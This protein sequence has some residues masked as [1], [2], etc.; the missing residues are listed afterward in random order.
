MLGVVLCTGG[1]PVSVYAADLV[2]EEIV[3]T[4]QKRE[5][6]LQDVPLSITAVT[7]D[8]LTERGIT[9]LSLLDSAVPGLNI[10]QSGSD[11]RPS[12]RGVPT[13]EIDLFN[14][15]TIGFFV[16]GVYKGRTSQALAAFAD[17]ERVEVLRGPQGT[18]Q[19]RNTFGG[20]V[21]LITAKPK[22]ENSGRLS[23]GFGN[24]DDQNVNGTVNVQLGESTAFRLTGSYQDSDG[25]VNV[26][27][28]RVPGG[29]QASDFNDN[30][31]TYFRG[32]LLHE[33]DNG[34]ILFT[35]S[36]W[37][38]GGFGTG[39]FGYTV[40]GALRDSAGNLDLGGT[41]DRNNPRNGA[42][43]GPSDDGP[44]DVYRDTDV[45]RDITETA[46]SLTATIDIGDLTL[47][48]ISG[49][50]D[51]NVERMNDDDFSD[52]AVTRL[53]L[54]TETESFSQE[55]QLI[56][57][58][59][60]PLQWVAGLYYYDE[61]GFEDFIFD[62]LTSGGAFTFLQQI[63]TSSY[64]GYV[65]GDYAVSDRLTFTLGARYTVDD[66]D[67]RFRFPSTAP[68]PNTDES[69]S[70][71]EFTWKAGAQY[72]VS[73][74]SLLYFSASTGFRSGGANN[75]FAPSPSYDA[76][77]ITAF[78][79]GWKSSFADG[80][81]TFNVSAYYNDLE[82]VLASGF[83]DF[84]A[85][86]VIVRTN[87]GEADVM[88]VEA[89]FAYRFDNGIAIDANASLMDA[90]YGTFAQPL[91]A[92]F[93]GRATGFTFQ[94]PVNAPGL[95]DLS[96]N[97][98]QVSPSYTVSLGIRKTFNLANG[99]SLTP[100]VRTYISDDYYL[101]AFNY[102]GGISGRQ[103]GQQESYTKTNASLTFE[104]ERYSVQAF[105]RNIEDEEVLTAAILGGQAALFQ[106][107]APP[108]TYGIKFGIQF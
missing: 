31:Q 36:H 87:A 61:S 46:F 44:Y 95:L 105:V 82:D 90:E 53:T 60:G 92:E 8:A 9:D 7:G 52:A 39:A 30:D 42:T 86:N 1:L 78:E 99:A 23:V 47:K 71:K 93:A 68:T 55:F 37:D 51:F 20:S 43:L 69:D 12:I 85:T 62:I 76:Q 33:F 70:F 81:G 67:F 13:I 75:Q 50:S 3:V 29:A 41:L 26:L 45:S 59:E 100:E 65:Q 64:A 57:S 27:P 25:Y 49:Y 6:N 28:S 77:T 58:G 66:K 72:V 2:I 54:E 19:G 14:D 79:L 10:G 94:D 91:R 80:A 83:V 38:R 32:S 104:T 88:G 18:L 74:D 102:D 4:A 97:E 106:N 63:D 11:V 24:F 22:F 16:D 73:D 15:P 89:E 107:Y 40:A 84:G 21:S 101:T 5:Q 35:A 98:V 108:R 96:G 48:S 103:A 17:L 56:S 34:E